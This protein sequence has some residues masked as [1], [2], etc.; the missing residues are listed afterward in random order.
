MNELFLEGHKELIKMVQWVSTP[1][2]YVPHGVIEQSALQDLK[3]GHIVLGHNK[4]GEAIE[5]LHSLPKD[6]VSLILKTFCASHMRL[7]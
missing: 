3:P 7:K 2:M 5:V 1:M 4:V 6:D